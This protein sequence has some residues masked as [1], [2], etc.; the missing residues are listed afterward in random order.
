ME[1]PFAG[2]HQLFAPLLDLLPNLPGPQRDA[3]GTV[4][5]FREGSPPERLLVG[6][7]ALSLLCVAAERKPLLCVID[8]GHWLDRASAQALAFV[9]R[10]PLAD[11]VGLVIATRE[12][13][14]WFLGLPEV[15]LGGLTAADAMVLLS[16]LPGAPLDSQVRDRIVA[17]AHGN[18]LA[19][20]EWHRALTPAAAVGGSQVAG[21]GSPPARRAAC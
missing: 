21:G 6:L 1:L 16:S 18:P 3:L 11:P 17:E 10:R 12:A 15:V 2:L 19:L 7:A 5:G 8:D 13:D 20:L 4:F 14:P 9:G